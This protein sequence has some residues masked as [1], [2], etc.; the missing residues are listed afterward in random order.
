L[1]SVLKVILVNHYQSYSECEAYRQTLP[2]Y[3]IDFHLTLMVASKTL[4]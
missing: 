4:I 3:T 1:V 2:R